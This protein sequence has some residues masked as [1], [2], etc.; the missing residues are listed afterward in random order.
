VAEKRNRG[1][2]REGKRTA[3]AYTTTLLGIPTPPCAD[4]GCTDSCSTEGKHTDTIFYVVRQNRLHPRKRVIVL[5]IEKGLQQNTWRRRITSTL[6]Y[7]QLS[8]TAVED[9]AMAAWQQLFFLSS[10]RHFTLCTLTI[11][12]SLLSNNCFFYRQ[13]WSTWRGQ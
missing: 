13:T 6:L 8:H 2:R 10:S 4:R 3:A 5:E 9:A 12:S 1:D 11:L 7:S